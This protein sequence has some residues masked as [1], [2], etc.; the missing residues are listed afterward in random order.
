MILEPFPDEPEKN[1]GY[2][3]VIFE[4]DTSEFPNFSTII[5]PHQSPYDERENLLSCYNIFSWQGFRV[6]KW[7][8]PHTKKVYEMPVI[9]L[10]IEDYEDLHDLERKC[11]TGPSGSVPEEWMTK[12]GEI[13]RS[14]NLTPTQMTYHL[15]AMWESYDKYFGAKATSHSYPIDWLNASYDV[16]PVELAASKTRPDLDNMAFLQLLKEQEANRQARRQTK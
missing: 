5:L 3:N 15:K 7:V 2:Q 1:K 6:N 14:R 12:R 4:I 11:I 8:H 10:K 13:V 16:N 9:S